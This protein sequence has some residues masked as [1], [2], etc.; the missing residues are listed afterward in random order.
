MALVHSGKEGMAARLVS[1]E[2]LWRQADGQRDASGCEG[3]GLKGQEVNQDDERRT[4]KEVNQLFRCVRPHR[5]VSTDVFTEKLIFF[6]CIF[7]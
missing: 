6:P 3:E 2:R 5:N 7:V 1:A 4:T